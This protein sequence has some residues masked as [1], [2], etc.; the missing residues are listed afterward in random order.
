MNISNRKC[1]LT[2]F[3]VTLVVMMGCDGTNA[4]VVSQ[5][6]EEP[7]E[8][9]QYFPLTT[10]KVANFEVTNEV[11]GLDSKD[12]YIVGEGISDGNDVS[13]LWIHTNLDFPNQ[14]DTGYFVQTST[15]LYYY[16]DASADPELILQA[17]F[18]VGQS[19]QRHNANRV[20]QNLVD[21]LI[22]HLENKYGGGGST[23]DEDNGYKDID[24]DNIGDNDGTVISGMGKNYPLQASGYLTI[25]AI[26]DLEM[27]NGYVLEDCIKVESQAGSQYT[28]IYWYA[29]NL[30]L[31]KY[32]LGA[33]E[34]TLSTEAPSGQVVGQRQ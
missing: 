33:T 30:G 25:T 21:S 8:I 19:W 34:E 28:N 27:A 5:P 12:R 22:G 15:G 3:L 10:G 6:A 2:L 14:P 13:Y 17:P 23:G 4:P 20:G 24:G 1:F 7:S 9:E 18:K 11:T 16:E 32:I 26:E 31:V 29:K